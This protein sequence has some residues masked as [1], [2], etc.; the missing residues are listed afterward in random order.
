MQYCEG[1]NGNYFL[2][3]YFKFE[4]GLCLKLC[5]ET[6]VS[7]CCTA[8]LCLNCALELADHYQENGNVKQCIFCN[9][10]IEYNYIVR[11]A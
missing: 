10:K 7:D 11:D 2:L 9:V 5:S 6:L 3:K 4:C 8:P 1:I